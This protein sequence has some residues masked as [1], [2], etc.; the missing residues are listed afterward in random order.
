[1]YETRAERHKKF[2]QGW[3]EDARRYCLNSKV[4]D[5]ALLSGLLRSIRFYQRRISENDFYRSCG[6]EEEN[7][8]II[9]LLC[10]CPV[11]GRRRKRHLKTCYIEDLDEL[12]CIDIGG[13][14]RKL[15]VFTRIGENAELWHHNGPCVRPKR[16]CHFY[17]STGLV[18]LK[19][20]RH[21]QQNTK[22]GKI[23]LS[24]FHLSRFL[25]KYGE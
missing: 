20:D 10:T 3:I 17:L 4:V 8:A 6:D 2:S 7:E 13:I 9:H 12:S 1:M 23:L 5:S 11:L 21:L 15:R 14:H 22:Y 24:R 16:V 25:A 19:S 18:N